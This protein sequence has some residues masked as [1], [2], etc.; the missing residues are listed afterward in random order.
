MTIIDC[1]KNFYPGNPSLCVEC[2]KF[3]KVVRDMDSYFFTMNAFKD[4]LP[5]HQQDNQK[6]ISEFPEFLASLLKS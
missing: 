4:E 5:G 1:V 6:E 2:C 3:A